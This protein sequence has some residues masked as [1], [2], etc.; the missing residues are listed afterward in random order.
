[1]AINDRSAPTELL[2]KKRTVTP[3]NDLPPRKDPQPREVITDLGWYKNLAVQ[4]KL[5]QLKSQTSIKVA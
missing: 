5:P 4:Q 1:L 3:H 2:W